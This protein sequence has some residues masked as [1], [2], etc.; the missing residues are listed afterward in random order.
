LNDNTETNCSHKKRGISA[1]IEQV[2]PAKSE[3][4]MSSVDGTPNVE[5]R[6]TD[7]S[8]SGFTGIIGL[9]PNVPLGTV[10]VL[11]QMGNDVLNLAPRQG[12]DLDVGPDL[13]KEAKVKVLHYYPASG[14]RT[15]YVTVLDGK[16]AGQNGWIFALGAETVDG[17]LVSTLDFAIATP[18]PTAD[19]MT[20]TYTLTGHLRAFSDLDVCKA[21]LNA[22]EDSAAYQQLKD[23]VANGAYHDFNAGTKLHIVSD[24]DPNDLWLIV[25]DDDGNQ[26]CV[27]RYNL[28]S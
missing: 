3:D 24:P 7:G 16:Y 27:S 15:L 8:W 4:D 11:K 25:S 10:I 19:P 18:A 14:D 20:R 12:S 6:A 26:G 21:S 2:I 1:I 22:M 5:I 28:P 23:A 9:Q 17:K 13:G